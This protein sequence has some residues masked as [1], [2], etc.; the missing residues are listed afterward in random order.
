MPLS[1]YWPEFLMVALAHLMA[2]ASPG[3]DF[4]IV[5]RQSLVAGRRAALLTSLGIGTAILVHV[6][7]SLLGIGIMIRSSDAAFSV[8]KWA[9]AAYLVYLAFRCLTAKPA[10]EDQALAPTQMEEGSA[11]RRGAFLTGFITNVLN[12]KATLF[13][14]ALF[15]AGISQQTPRWVVVGYGFWMALATAAWFC[16][17]SIIFTQASAVL[18]FRRHAHWIDRGTGVI[19][20]LFAVKLALAAR[21]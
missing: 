17:V 11:A 19:L 20:L 21:S 18:R 16:L 2:V 5:L 10:A 6:A 1:S 4:A 12:P 9:G 3:P 14:L 7:Y 13:F 8:V 15:S